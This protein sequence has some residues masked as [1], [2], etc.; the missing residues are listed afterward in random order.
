[1]ADK[2][3]DRLTELDS[4]W[5]RA[6]A[7]ALEPEEAM[8][9]MIALADLMVRF[10]APAVETLG[11]FIK[12]MQEAGDADQVSARLMSNVFSSLNVVAQNIDNL[13]LSFA[14]L[15]RLLAFDQTQVTTQPEQ[16]EQATEQV[17]QPVA[18][19]AADSKTRSE[20]P[21]APLEGEH[22]IPSSPNQA[23]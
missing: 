6:T 12:Q 22:I 20:I 5:L 9:A 21:W 2:V 7:D 8:R 19:A 4:L 17:A 13:Q 16:V 11:G 14:V 18:E 23:R 10:G 1:M 3:V 15:S